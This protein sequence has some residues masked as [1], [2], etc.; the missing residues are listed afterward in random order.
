MS[1]QP[2]IGRILLDGKA[3]ATRAD[4][5][6]QWLKLQPF[7]GLPTPENVTGADWQSKIQGRTGIIQFSSYWTS[8][9]E[10][11]GNASGGHIDLW[12]KDILMPSTESFLRF[13]L[14]FSEIS[15]PLSWLRGRSDNL[16]SDLGTSEQIL[17]W[18]VR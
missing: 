3:T 6:G 17:F 2:G 13:R 5:M 10:S 11:R 4:E 14:G 15:H 1:G 16:Y 7:A 12:N 9:G 18:E 8:D